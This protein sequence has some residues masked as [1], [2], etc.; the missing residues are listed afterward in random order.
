[1]SSTQTQK[2]GSY[3]DKFTPEQK[4]AYKEKKV[5]EKQEYHELYKKFKK[6]KKKE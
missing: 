2:R 6:I 3:K 1:M 5:T 4:R